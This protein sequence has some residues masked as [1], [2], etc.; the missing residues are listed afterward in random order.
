M[1]GSISNNVGDG[2]TFWPDRT[3]RACCDAHDAAYSLG[4][5]KLQ[6]DWNLLTCVLPYDPI[7][8][9]LMFGGVS[10][11]GWLWWLKARRR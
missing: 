2:C 1:A 6:A 5:D 11:F 9:V 7:A 4:I 3:W 10:L 8:A